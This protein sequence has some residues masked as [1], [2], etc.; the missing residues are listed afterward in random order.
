MQKLIL[1]TVTTL[2]SLIGVSQNQAPK[3]I[4][5]PINDIKKGKSQVISITKLGIDSIAILFPAGG[6]QTSISLYKSKKST[7]PLRYIGFAFEDDESNLMC[8]SKSDIGKYYVRL[9]SCHWRNGFFLT[10]K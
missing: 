7:D 4:Y 10:I 2:I 8:F 1:I 9:T 6:T 3:K 5:I